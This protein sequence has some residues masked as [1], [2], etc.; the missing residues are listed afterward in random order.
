VKQHLLPKA[1]HGDS[2]EINVENILLQKKKIS[3]TLDL[4]Q[5]VKKESY[6]GFPS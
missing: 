4:S 5:D 3:S 6:Q 1:K 2:I